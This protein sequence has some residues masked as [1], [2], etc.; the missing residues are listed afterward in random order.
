[1]VKGTKLAILVEASQELTK[2]ED[3]KI[4]EEYKNSLKLLVEEQ[5]LNRETVYFIQYG[6]SASP[7]SPDPLPFAVS[8]SHSKNVAGQ[9]IASLDGQGSCNLLSALKVA[10]SLKEV[11]TILVVLC[12][13]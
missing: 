3:G 4:F 2:V 12:T 13:K 6:T 7:K 11:D 1:M 5:L 8:R 10:L 9:W